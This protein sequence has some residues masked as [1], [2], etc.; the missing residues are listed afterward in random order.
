MK[1]NHLYSDNQ[2]YSQFRLIHVNSNFKLKKK[3]KPPS[4]I[5]CKPGPIPTFFLCRLDIFH[6]GLVTCQARPFFWKYVIK[7]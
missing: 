3:L 5:E 4:C 6:V 7:A 1:K 2:F